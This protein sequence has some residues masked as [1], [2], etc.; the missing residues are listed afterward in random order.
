MC[1]KILKAYLFCLVAD[2]QIDLHPAQGILA[3]GSRNAKVDLCTFL[4]YV[5]VFVIALQLIRS[6]QGHIK[7]N[8]NCN[9]LAATLSRAMTN[10]LQ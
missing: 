7:Q 4:I 10:P 9:Q 2:N 1:N 6:I 3:I 5:L 8:D